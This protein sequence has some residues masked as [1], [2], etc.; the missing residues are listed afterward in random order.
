[1]I[2]EEELSKLH[3]VTFVPESQ[4]SY[5]KDKGIEVY[6]LPPL[7]KERGIEKGVILSDSVE[8]LESRWEMFPFTKWSPRVAVL[9][10]EFSRNM[11]LAE[12]RMK[13][14]ETGRIAHLWALSEVEPHQIERVEGVI[15]T[16]PRVQ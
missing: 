16:P 2:V 7:F 12:K 6:Q 10:V 11:L 4:V 13:D 3:G 8:L 1:M 5:F 14:T 15:F 9:K